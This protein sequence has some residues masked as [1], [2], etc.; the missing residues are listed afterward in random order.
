MMAIGE[1]D[2]VFMPDHM[3]ALR[4]RIRGCPPPMRVAQAG[5]FVQEH[6]EAIAIEAVR[7]LA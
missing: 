5:H 2:P 3:E 7:A 6:G 1:R 4:R